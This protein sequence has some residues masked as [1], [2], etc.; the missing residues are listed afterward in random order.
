MD[1]MHRRCAAGDGI[2]SGGACGDQD[3]K[4]LQR[5]VDLGHLAWNR[6]ETFGLS[7]R[8]RQFTAVTKVKTGVIFRPFT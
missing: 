3:P 8:W 5:A 1:A 7:T 4:P 6:A 2:T